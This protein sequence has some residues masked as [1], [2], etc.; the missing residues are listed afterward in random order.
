[1]LI[2]GGVN[3]ATFFENYKLNE[4]ITAFYIR[5]F[6]LS[7]CNQ[8]FSLGAIGYPNIGNCMR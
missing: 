8:F 7:F 4:C 6:P 3:F 1:M 5:E 2:F